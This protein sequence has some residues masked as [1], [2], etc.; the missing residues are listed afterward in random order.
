M[1]QG[2]VIKGVERDRVMIRANAMRIIR[3]ILDRPPMKVKGA[4]RDW[5]APPP[6]ES[7]RRLEPLGFGMTDEDWWIF[8]P[9]DCT[10]DIVWPLNVGYVVESAS[11]S[12]HLSMSRVQTISAKQARGFASRF[13][14]FMVRIDHAQEADGE[15]LRAAGLYVW[16]GGEWVDAQKRTLWE[17]RSSEVA[18]PHKSSFITE[19]DKDQPRLATAIAL[20]QRYEWAVALGMERSPTIRFATDPTG[21]KEIFRIRDL[22]A[23]RDRR[24][25]LLTW[26]TDHWR[27]TR[28]DPDV[29]T[30]VRKHLRGAVGFAW[31]GMQGE[32]I[33]AQYDVEMRDR[34]IADRAALKAAGRDRRPRIGTPAAQAET[35]LVDESR[36]TA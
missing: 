27:Q 11:A 6:Y 30:Y 36:K 23:G 16:L 33:P 8:H 18:V 5:L 3:A 17:G 2:R 35:N 29:E 21:I 14:P 13:G 7:F 28:E 1:T 20:R 32:I 25:A 4:R 15:L 19:Q 22:P 12:D 31:Q 34:M 10:P 9:K 24:D 26:V